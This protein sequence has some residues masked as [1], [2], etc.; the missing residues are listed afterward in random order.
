LCGEY[1]PAANDYSSLILKAKSGAADVLLTLPTPPDGI[2]MLKQMKE[3]DFSPKLAYIVR[4]SDGA[5]WTRN[6]GKD[7]DLV[8]NMPGW[9]PDLSYP[10]NAQLRNAHDGTYG[11]AAEGL[12]GAAY[13]AVQV[14]FDAFQRVG[15]PTRDALRDAISVTDTITVSG[16]VTFNP[17]GTANIVTVINQWVDGRQTVV[18]PPEHATQPLR[19]PA[20]A[21]RERLT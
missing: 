9:S 5:V 3:L 7:G 16:P 12:V 18:L 14:L 20:A 4:A 8:L 1:A 13:A 11:K 10:G 17:D 21:W 15:R 2:A 19:Y 6:L